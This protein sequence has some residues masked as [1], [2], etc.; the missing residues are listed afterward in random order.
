MM[1]ARGYL[2]T[3]GRDK[4]VHVPPGAKLW[5]WGCSCATWGCCLPSL[6]AAREGA[7]GHAHWHKVAGQ[8]VTVRR[9]R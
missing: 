1:A 9:R 3:Y 2:T 5:E 8:A 4:H 7:K 6:E